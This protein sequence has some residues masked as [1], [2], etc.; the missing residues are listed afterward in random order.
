M[1]KGLELMISLAIASFIL[2]AQGVNRDRYYGSFQVPDAY[3]HTN[4]FTSSVDGQYV[5]NANKFLF[6]APSTVYQKG[7][8]ILLK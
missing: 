8:M 6:S 1:F 7:I 2:A 3:R 4:D 5:V